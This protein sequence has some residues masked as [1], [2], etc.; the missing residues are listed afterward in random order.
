[1]PIDGHVW[2]IVSDIPADRYSAERIEGRLKD[3]GWLSI[4]ALAHE[5][6]VEHF[7]RRGALVPL[8]LFTIFASED[9]AVQH[10]RRRR[11]LMARLL[12][13]VTGCQ[14]WGVRLVR[15][16]TRRRGIDAAAERA[17]S[18]TEFLQHK[19][20]ARASRQAFTA[21]ERGVANRIHR[22]LVPYARAATRGEQEPGW[23][24]QAAPVLQAAYLIEGSGARFRT[25][26]RRLAR[27]ARAE[28][29]HLAVT[30][31][32]PPYHFVGSRR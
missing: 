13:R 8:K 1:V 3:L 17:A 23:S 19:Q 15:D 2:V 31:P 26:V 18:G 14:E 9:R 20:R 4:C 25:A 24:G 10:V 7:M 11:R 5:R 29:Y 12:D 21:R 32:W 16:L 27:E 28:G 6:V 30:G 22:D